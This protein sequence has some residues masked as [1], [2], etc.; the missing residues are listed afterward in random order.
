MP[1]ALL[2]L[3]FEAHLCQDTLVIALST[4]GSPQDP[5]DSP[6]SRKLQRTRFTFTVKPSINPLH[7]RLCPSFLQHFA[8]LKTG[9]T[10]VTALRSSPPHN[11][12]YGNGG[13]VI[14]I[15]IV[16]ELERGGSSV[17]RVG[18]SP[19]TNSPKIIARSE[20]KHRK[21][22]VFILMTTPVIKIRMTQT[23]N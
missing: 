23:V 14:V 9:V 8:T 19:T 5:F 2:A 17:A 21:R 20:A 6:G 7:F 3:N 4:P 18:E 22:S 13:V 11:I 1:I 16:A 15:V 10:Q 12:C